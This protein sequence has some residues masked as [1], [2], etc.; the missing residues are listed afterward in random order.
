MRNFVLELSEVYREEGF[1]LDRMD[2]HADLRGLEGSSCFC[3]A[4]AAASVSAALEGMLSSG[5]GTPLLWAD[6]G[7]YHYVSYLHALLLK[8]PFELCLIDNH[9]DDFDFD[10]L[11]SCG[12]WVSALRGG[13]LCRRDVWLSREEDFQKPAG[14]ELPLFLSIDLDVLRPGDFVTNWDQ[15]EVR[16]G[17]LLD[18]VRTLCSGRKVAGVD[19]CGGITSS[20]GA[21]GRDLALNAGCRM[22]IMNFFKEIEI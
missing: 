21:T 8:E 2:G 15:G 22:K 16:L 6:T 18:Y 9:S 17:S 20:K 14:V 12:N 10:G 5:E 3:T 19:I 4:E 1:S 7:D 11:L 13:G